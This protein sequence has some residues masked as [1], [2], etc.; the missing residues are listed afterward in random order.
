MAPT[1][2]AEGSF[3]LCRHIIEKTGEKNPSIAHHIVSLHGLP[4]TLTKCTALH[5]AAE[6]GHLDIAKLIIDSKVDKNPFESW[7]YTP[8]YYSAVGDNAA[9]WELFT[10]NLEDKNP[11][12][13]WGW[14]PCHQA[15]RC[16]SLKILRSILDNVA[17]K[18]HPTTKGPKCWSYTT[19]HCCRNR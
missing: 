5:F 10:N 12:N 15:A 11:E 3:E 8:L 7:G 2:A 19:S 18:N 1:A 14:T 16:G 13:S 17:D 6:N 4:K 9:V